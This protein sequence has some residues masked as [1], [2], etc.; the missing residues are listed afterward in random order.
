[1]I[2]KNE[3]KLKNFLLKKSQNAIIQ[4]QNRVYDIIKSFLYR[5]YQE[6]DPVEYERTWQL[7]NSLVQTRI[8]RTV[9]GYEAE[10]YFD[11]NSLNYI[12]GSQPSGKQVMDA[13]GQGDHGVE[14]VAYRGTAVWNEPKMILDAKAIGILRDMLIAE[15]VP[16]R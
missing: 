8:V 2:F 7:F 11:Y 4:A 3:T 16:I 12:G 9:N 6:F 15:G 5:Y 1:M 10:V 13:A 14:V